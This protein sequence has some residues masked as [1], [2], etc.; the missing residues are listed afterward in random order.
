MLPQKEGEELCHLGGART[1]TAAPPHKEDPSEITQMLEL[2]ASECL[3]QQMKGCIC[4]YVYPL[5]TS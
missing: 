4:I 5:Q 3:P 1:R 2:D